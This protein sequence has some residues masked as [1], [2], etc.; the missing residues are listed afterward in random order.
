MAKAIAGTLW[1]TAGGEE[2][3]SRGSIRFPLSKQMQVIG[4]T[5]LSVSVTQCLT[6]PKARKNQ[7]EN[8]FSWSS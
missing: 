5:V 7:S 3:S 1:T 4:R 2:K 8:S 6:H